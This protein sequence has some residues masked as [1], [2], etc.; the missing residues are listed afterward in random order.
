MKPLNNWTLLKVKIFNDKMRLDAGRII[1]LDNSFEPEKHSS[2]VCEVV[3]PPEGLTFNQGQNSMPWDTE[4]DLQAGDE[5][6][7]HYLAYQNAFGKEA[8]GD[9]VVE[10]DGEVCFFCK[11]ESIFCAKRKWSD[12]DTEEFFM[13][14]SKPRSREDLAKENI[15]VDWGKRE[16]YSVIMLNGYLAC[17]PIEEEIKTTLILPEYLKKKRETNRAIV[18]YL[19]RCNKAYLHHPDMG[20][21][22]DMIESGDVVVLS[23]N[24]GDIPLEYAQHRTFDGEKEYWRVQRCDVKGVIKNNSLKLV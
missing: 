17:E 10:A 23:H 5:V 21:D 22:M 2:V 8:L 3:C 11:Y 16:I 24:S 12:S 9:R 13:I 19:G 18:R 7:I 14:N 1:W 4:M 20:G 6:I 15:V